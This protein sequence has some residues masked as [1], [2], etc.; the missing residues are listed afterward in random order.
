M[1]TAKVQTLCVNCH[2]LTVE[3]MQQLRKPQTDDTEAPPPVPADLHGQE[4]LYGYVVTDHWLLKTYWATHDPAAQPPH[5]YLFK[6][7]KQNVIYDVAEQLGLEIYIDCCPYSEEED[8]AWFSY[9]D[10][11]VVKIMEVPTASRLECFAKEL[12]ITEKARWLDTG[13][14]LLHFAFLSL[15]RRPGFSL[16]RTRAGARCPS[17]AYRGTPG[18]YRS[19]VGRVN[20]EGSRLRRAAIGADVWVGTRP[21]FKSGARCHSILPDLPVLFGVH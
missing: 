1:P 2:K 18:T 20:V 14:P 17:R 6:S 15:A 12:G 9:T 3:L 10:G 4:C 11:G 13:V 16:A 8:I 19:V 7:Y 21:S 5:E